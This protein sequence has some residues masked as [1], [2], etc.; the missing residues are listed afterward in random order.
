MAPP[1]KKKTAREK[2]SEKLDAAQ[3]IVDVLKKL[4]EDARSARDECQKTYDHEGAKLLADLDKK[5][6]KDS[7][8]TT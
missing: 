3:N 4:L 5:K 7:K 2:A 1:E 6:K 8:R